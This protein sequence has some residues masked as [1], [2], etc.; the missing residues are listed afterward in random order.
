MEAMIDEAKKRSL[1]IHRAI[2]E[3]DKSDEINHKKGDTYEGA[4]RRRA[5][6]GF[7]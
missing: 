4:L 7:V 2:E 3:M 5:S 1:P 6:E